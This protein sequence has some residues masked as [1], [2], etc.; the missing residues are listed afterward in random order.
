MGA[1]LWRTRLCR[2]NRGQSDEDEERRWEGEALSKSLGPK[3]VFPI[4]IR[5]LRHIMN[6]CDLGRLGGET[7]GYT[8]SRRILDGLPRV[9]FRRRSIH[10]SPSEPSQ[11]PA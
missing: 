7:Q 6:G 3:P 8:E 4:R 9:M 5:A 1:S 2:I 10:V 11:T